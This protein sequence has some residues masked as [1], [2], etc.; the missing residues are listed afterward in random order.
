MNVLRDL[1]RQYW[2]NL[3]VVGVFVYAAF[4]YCQLNDA[5]DL[6]RHLRWI[7]FA[8][9]G[10]VMFIGSDEWSEWSGHYGLTRQHW[11]MAPGSYFRL[12]GGVLLVW[13]TIAL[14]RV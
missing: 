11:I 4:R 7:V 5:F 1:L 12:V 10:M 6:N 9:G 13:F 3:M 8:F 2:A 14:H